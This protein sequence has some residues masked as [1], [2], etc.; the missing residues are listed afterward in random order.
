MTNPNEAMLQAVAVNAANASLRK[1]LDAE[2]KRLND[3]LATLPSFLRGLNVG[4]FTIG[5][6]STLIPEE[7]WGLDL[8]PWARVVIGGVFL[9]GAANYLIRQRGFMIAKR[10]SRA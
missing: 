10:I 1:K 6:L 8:P 4:A 9:L 3:K 7:F 5:G 2:R